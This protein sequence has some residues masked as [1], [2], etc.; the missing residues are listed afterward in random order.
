M[1]LK[2]IIV[3][4]ISGS[5]KGTQGKLIQEYLEKTTD[6]PV[7]YIE[8]GRFFR[9]FMKEDSYASEL[10][11]EVGK[12]GGLQPVFLAVWSWGGR[13][14]K[15]ITGNEHVIIDGSPRI[16]SESSLLHHAL[17][18]FKRE[19]PYV[20]YLKLSDEEAKSRLQARGRADDEDDEAIYERLRWFKERA[21][22]AI[23]YFQ[24]QQG[25]HYHEIDGSLSVEEIHEQIKNIID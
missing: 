2:T 6:K 16:L 10:A 13:M 5:G 8:T 14:V 7:E 3:A 1:K 20:I 25:F 23:K 15:K 19:T 9:D 22:P 18:F 12:E 4:G 11:R 17:K 24:T 21:L